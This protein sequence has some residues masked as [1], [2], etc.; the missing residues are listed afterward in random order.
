MHNGEM[1]LVPQRF[2]SAHRRMQ[3]E[4]AVQIDDAVS[5]T[6]WPGNGNARAHV[7]VRLLGVRH[8]DVEPVGGATLEQ[9]HQALTA[10]TCRRLRSVD[11]ARQETRNNA[12]THDRQRAVPKEYSAG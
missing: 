10:A 12:G 3:S 7:V 5:A 6:A 4:E 2:K 9:H 8:N 1:L 11:R